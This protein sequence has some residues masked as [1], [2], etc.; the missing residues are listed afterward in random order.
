MVLAMRLV[1]GIFALFFLV[2]TY[3]TVKSTARFRDRIRIALA[4]K[5]VGK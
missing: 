5:V 1:M 2:E 3:I 4:D